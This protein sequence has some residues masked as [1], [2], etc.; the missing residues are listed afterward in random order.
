[1]SQP[2]FIFSDLPN[3]LFPQTQQVCVVT[4][5]LDACV[6]GFADRLGIG[7]WW[8]KRYAPPELTDLKLRGEPAEMSAKVALAWTGAMNWE[9]VQPLDGRGP[10][11]EYLEAQGE[12]IHHVACLLSTLGMDWPGCH[13]EFE[14][15]DFSR[16]HEGRW[17]GVTFCYYETLDPSHTTFEVIHREEGWERPD[18]D[19]WYP[20]PPAR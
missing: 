3:S 5:D 10:H 13:R 4:R 18:P 11:R 7:P 8:V 19:Y 15:R 20:K 16:L 9:I 17:Q 14:S 12:G 6:R 1:M 2:D